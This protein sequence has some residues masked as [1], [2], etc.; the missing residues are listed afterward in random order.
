MHPPEGVLRANLVTGYSNA[1]K[2]KAMMKFAELEV[3]PLVKHPFT[4]TCQWAFGSNW[5][6]RK[7]YLSKW[8][9]AVLRM[10]N[11]TKRMTSKS[12]RNFEPRHSWSSLPG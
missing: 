7:G 1:Q 10:H 6:N 9:N 12:R 2:W 11:R 4:A 5:Q 8:R 3:N